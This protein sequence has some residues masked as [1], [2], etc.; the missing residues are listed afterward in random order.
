MPQSC[1]VLFPT[2]MAH[3][4]KNHVGILTTAAHLMTY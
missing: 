4:A 1:R 2:Q 3:W